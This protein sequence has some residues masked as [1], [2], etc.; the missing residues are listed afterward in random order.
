MSDAVTVVICA[1][2]E[3]RWAQIGRAVASVR[4][5]RRPAE[6][7][8]L[9]VDHNPGLLE[10]ARTA[11]PELTVVPS[12]GPRGLSGARN[13]GVARARGDLVAF[14]DDDAEAEPDWLA[15]LLP[16]Y[17]DPAVL[18]V[19]G[20][21][22]PAWAGARPRWLPPE[23][24]WVVGCSFTG[25][26]AGAAPVR[27]VIGCNMSFRRS[28]LDGT[29]GFHP[30]LGRVGRTPV[31]CEET[32]LCIRI[33]RAHPGGVVLY[34][35]A[36]LVRHRVDA[37][38]A[39][40]RYFRRRCF[41]EGRSKAVVARLA[42]TADALSA[43][44]AYT[45]RTLPDGVRRGL[46]EVR[47]GDRAG[48]LRSGAIV[49]GLLVTA[50]GYASAQA[51]GRASRGAPDASPRTAAPATV[52]GPMRVLEVELSDGVPA[53]ADR[54]RPDGPR[55]PGA[56][57]LVRL[58][59]QPLGVLDLA[60]PPGGLSA[61]AHAGAIGRRL[62]GAID[63]HLR[64]DGL[65]PRDLRSAE[66]TGVGAACPSRP[67]PRGSGPPVSV[68]VPTC[69]RTTLL[70]RTLDALAAQD[71]PDY[72]I[73]VVDN[74]PA[75][76]ATARLV[77]RRAAT[78]PRLRCVSES[79]AG[80]THARNRGLADARGAIVA[81]VDDDVRVDRGWLRAL[82]DGFADAR[83]AGVT[84]QLLA[85]EL[86]TP[87]QIWVERYGGFGKGCRRRRFD[88]DG[89]ETVE[90]GELRRIPAGPGSLYP[91]LPGGYG[92][93]ANMAFRTGVLRGLGGFDPRLGSGEDIDALLRLVLAGHALV[94][95]PAAIG[96]HAHRRELP[97]LR[98]TMYHY[99][100]GL[101]AVLAKCLATDAAGRR[102]LVRRLPRGIAY[103]VLPTS[104][105]NAGKR[106]GYPVS[107]TALELC[108]MALGPA[109]YA[110]AAWSRRRDG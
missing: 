101:S 77:E 88:R 83:V 97:A 44:R 103:A 110:V 95:E 36:A 107:L 87:A 33:R 76:P 7:L 3:R 31:G 16:H 18:A 109:Y 68:V 15:T 74:T 102:E 98:R 73:V 2:T 4:A 94:Y 85:G 72:E 30:G 22:V 24:D 93:G 28:I 65:P 104:A 27:N 52:P 105:K 69:G 43:E 89:M 1:Y 81:Y 78:D 51:L 19:G 99:G 10:R 82:V 40:W 62:S 54:T 5:Q 75:E 32:E 17:R 63:E 71:Y 35:P 45:H 67:A 46:R 26:P 34:E 37:D 20:R 41:S 11:F 100:V 90:G 106:G 14:L 92:S 56:Q 61:R 79:R 70:D 25:Q 66:L 13:T 50:A 8:V 64:R 55:Y 12:A 21:A 60:L 53:L 108:G 39:T 80:V 59:G 6:E 29:S 23:F 96:W 86:E 38:R 48:L 84:G 91:Y 49:A 47:S 57:V 9:V 58:H 42:G